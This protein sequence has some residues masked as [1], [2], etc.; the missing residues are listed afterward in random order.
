MANA[1]A[2]KKNTSPVEDNSFDYGTSVP[3]ASSGMQMNT[4]MMTPAVAREVATIQ[5]QAVMAKMYPRSL[6]DAIKRIQ[7]ECSRKALAEQAV[8]KFKKGK[9]EVS[10]ASIRLAEAIARSYGNM[11]Y[12]FD[13]QS[14]ENGASHV[15]AYCYDL[16]T[17]VFAERIFSVSHVLDTR[18]GSRELTE[19]R[20]IYE[21][22]ANQS[23]RRVR[24]CIL[25]MIPGDVVDF[26]INECQKTLRSSVVVD[27]NAI[28]G[29]IEAF[30]AF[31]VTKV[32]LEAY[33]DRNIESIQAEQLISL[34]QIYKGIKEGMARPEETFLSYEEAVKEREGMAKSSIEEPVVAD[35]EPVQE[36]APAKEPQKKAAPAPQ[37]PVQ[38]EPQYDE[39]MMGGPEGFDDMYE[40][41]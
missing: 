10:G 34:R 40:D 11:K 26:A 35:V 4:A 13:V 19:Q 17:N 2:K 31:G 33:L 41:L 18:D 36:P 8:Y 3:A 15:R 1:I 22:V 37:K 7:G 16:E 28:L 6:P 5:A 9:G 24:A 12:G 29:I 32:Q 30:K 14:T 27:N 38:P 39:P 25:E 21:M 20:D 23:Q